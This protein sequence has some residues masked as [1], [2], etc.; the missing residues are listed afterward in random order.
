MFD[1]EAYDAWFCAKVLAAINDKGP[2][3]PH[4]EVEAVLA[5]KRGE[6]GEKLAS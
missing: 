3:I 1:R 6:L 5:A 4:E 2:V